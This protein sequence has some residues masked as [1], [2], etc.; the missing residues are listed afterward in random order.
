MPIIVYLDVVL[1]RRKVSLQWSAAALLSH[2]LDAAE[3]VR[4]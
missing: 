4:A 3:Q 1:A 2:S